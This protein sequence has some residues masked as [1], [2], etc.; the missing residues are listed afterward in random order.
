MLRKYEVL[1]CLQLIFEKIGI[2]LE[3]QRSKDVGEY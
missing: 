2:A 1:A 3:Q